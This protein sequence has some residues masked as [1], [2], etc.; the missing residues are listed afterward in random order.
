MPFLGVRKT[1]KA[2][3]SKLKANG[4]RCQLI[5][6]RLEGYKTRRLESYENRTLDCSSKKT[7]RL[8]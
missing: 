4:E 7:V 6:Y 8:F 5:A 3:S 2:E 1:V